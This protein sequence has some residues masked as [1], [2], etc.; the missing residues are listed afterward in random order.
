M[1]KYPIT[2]KNLDGESVTRDYYFNLSIP[3]VTELE[4]GM[5]GGM[6]AYWIDL[7][8]RGDQGGIV[9]ALKDIV[10]LAY[11]VR[12]E[13]GIT[14]NKSPEIS[15]KFLQSDAYSVLFMNFFGPEASNEAFTNWLKAVV[16]PEI[17]ERVPSDLPVQETPNTVKAA[18]E[19]AKAEEFSRNELLVMTDEEFA[20]VA[21][22]DPSKMTR[23]VLLV[24]MARKNKASIN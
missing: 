9:K 21:G 23:D 18:G 1:L 4:V 17:L 11:G 19:R 5:P 3:E 2:F 24:A 13:D 14:F 12:D 7:V 22:R 6:S 20:K 10:A 8:E 15:R 16:P